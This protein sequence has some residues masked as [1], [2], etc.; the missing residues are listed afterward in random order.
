MYG[1]FTNRLVFSGPISL[2]CGSFPLDELSDGLLDDFDRV[3]IS[4][5]DG[6][7]SSSTV[8]ILQFLSA[9]HLIKPVLY[10]SDVRLLR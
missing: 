5:K 10:L 1:S 6:F 2:L 8:H 4:Q 9:R 7:Q 3:V